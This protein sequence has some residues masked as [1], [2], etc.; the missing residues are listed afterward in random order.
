MTGFSIPLH[1]EERHGLRRASEAVRIG[2]PLPQGLLRESAEIAVT[3]SGG[4]PV[5]HQATPLAFWSD[6]SV[7]WLLVDALAALEPFE[8]A[9]LFLRPQPA[10]RGDGGPRLHVTARSGAIDVDTGVARFE[11]QEQHSGPFSSVT[12][13]AVSLLQPLGSRIRLTDRDTNTYEP[14]IE[15]LTIEEQGPVRAVVMSEG[16]FQGARGD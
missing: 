13:G 2:V 16:C 12:M 7:K 5:P 14:T 3:D 1:L 4:A 15:R 9:T 11:I 10:P 6:R 8:R